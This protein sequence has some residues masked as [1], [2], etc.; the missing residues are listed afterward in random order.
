M[1]ELKEAVSRAF[2]SVV[3]SGAIEQA[4]EKQ[5]GEAVT[6]AI[7]EQF[8]AYGDFSK[9]VKAKVAT[10]VGVNLDHIDLP[11]YRDLVSKIIQARVGAVMTEQFTEKLGRDLDEL[12]APAPAEIT[13]EA[14]LKEFIESKSDEWNI[15]QL[16]ECEFTLVID[17]SE[18]CKGYVSIYL[19]ED[20]DQSKH[21]C[22]IHIRMR[23]GGEV[24]GLEVGGTDIKSKIFVG[25]LFNFEKRLFQ[26]YT[27][28]TKLILAPDAEADDFETRFHFGSDDSDD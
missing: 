24:W 12:L 14:L 1:N 2:D 4:I 19:D 28:R 5:V 25:P 8:S 13:L 21:Q 16:R 7:R 6:A 3:A 10:L 15:S 11:S 23:D 18:N 9:A 27:A 17:R 26:L 22:A 20:A